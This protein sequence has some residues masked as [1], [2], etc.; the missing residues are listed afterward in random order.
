MFFSY[1]GLL[2]N[3][4]KFSKFRFFFYYQEPE[5]EPEPEP[6]KIVPVPKPKPALPNRQQIRA[7]TKELIHSSF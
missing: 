4:D 7:L 1:H 2:S 6:V 5:P 3:Y